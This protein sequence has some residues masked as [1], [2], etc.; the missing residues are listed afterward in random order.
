MKKHL[1]LILLSSLMLFSCCLNEKW[2]EEETKNMVQYATNVFAEVKNIVLNYEGIITEEKYDSNIKGDL[3]CHYFHS[4]YFAFNIDNISYQVIL[5]ITP[6]N[7]VSVHEFKLW[8]EG[9]MYSNP[10]ECVFKKEQYLVMIDLLES[11]DKL[12]NVKSFISLDQIEKYMHIAKESYTERK[13]GGSYRIK[14]NDRYHMVDYHGWFAFIGNQK[15]VPF[16]NYFSLE[17]SKCPDRFN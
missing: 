1:M 14:I 17:F 8:A 10:N 12:V 9:S 16:H 5:D 4:N 13:E 3:T 2:T 7:N 15:D 11:F 6:E